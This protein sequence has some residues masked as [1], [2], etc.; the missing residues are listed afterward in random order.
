MFLLPCSKQQNNSFQGL[1]VLCQACH[2]FRLWNSA[3]QSVGTQ[4]L[5]QPH[6]QHPLGQPR[7]LLC[8]HYSLS[9]I[10]LW[11]AVIKGREG[12]RR[13]GRRLGGKEE[14]RRSNILHQNTKKDCCDKC[15]HGININSILWMS[16]KES[17][18]V[19]FI[20]FH[21]IISRFRLQTHATQT[22]EELQ[23]ILLC[24]FSPRAHLHLSES[25]TVRV[26]SL[27]LFSPHSSTQDHF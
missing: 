12:G 5:Q 18:F 21:K 23:S 6:S 17:N 27:Q 11:Q 1:H 22:S 3:A 13:E 9:Q 2:V 8:T 14:G 7:G 25:S 20:H 10:F 24:G 19:V 15:Y 4:Q 26:I 16:Q